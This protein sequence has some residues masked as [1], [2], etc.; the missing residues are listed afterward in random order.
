MSGFLVVEDVNHTTAA[1]R[2]DQILGAVLSYS[3]KWGD[4]PIAVLSTIDRIDIEIRIPRR[5][6]QDAGEAVAAFFRRL[7]PTYQ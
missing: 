7:D 1:I 5:E 4:A 6:D 2:R 3:G